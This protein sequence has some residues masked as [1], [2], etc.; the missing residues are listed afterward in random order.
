MSPKKSLNS[1]LTPRILVGLLIVIVVVGILIVGSVVRQE[2]STHPVDVDTLA[3][4][5]EAIRRDVEASKS[6]LGHYPSTL[7]ELKATSIAAAEAGTREDVL[8]RYEGGAES[9][10]IAVMD[11]RDHYPA[12]YVKGDHVGVTTSI[13]Q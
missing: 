11:A 2:L 6:R 8:L 7:Q 1:K 4:V 10:V 3:K 5:A 13:D 9:F 12:V